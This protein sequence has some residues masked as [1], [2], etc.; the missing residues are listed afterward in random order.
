MPLKGYYEHGGLS[1]DKVDLHKV[2]FRTL[3]E[4]DVA[5]DRKDLETVVHGQSMLHNIRAVKGEIARLHN[6][7]FLERTEKGRLRIPAAL[8]NQIHKFVKSK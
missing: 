6:L 4:S 5:I 8:T 3:F 1:R 2:I 7:G